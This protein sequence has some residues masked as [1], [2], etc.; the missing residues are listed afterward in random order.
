VTAYA[1]VYTLVLMSLDRYLAVVHPIS[2]MSIRTEAN[3]LTAIA[4]IW[5]RYTNNL[6]I[7]FFCGSRHFFLTSFI[8]ILIV[9][10]YLMLVISHVFRKYKTFSIIQKLKDHLFELLLII[11]KNCKIKKEKSNLPPIT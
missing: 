1:S 9:M 2:S 3:T 8:P 11:G 7:F 10:G 6:F 4:V 5:V